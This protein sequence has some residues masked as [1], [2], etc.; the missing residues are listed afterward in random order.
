MAKKTALGKGLGALIEG[1]SKVEDGVTGFIKE[2]EIDKINP[3]PY[4]P[5]KE[6]DE[7][8]LE[9][10]AESIKAMGVIQ[11]ITINKND[12][13]SFTLISG[14]RRLRAA[15]LAHLET[16]PAYIRSTSDTQEMMEM[17]LVENIQRV[18]L[19]PISIAL[20]YQRLIDECQ[21]TQEKMSERIGKKR[22]TIANYLRLLKLPS[23]IQL[24]LKTNTISMGHA[25]AL[26]SID[27]SETQLMIYKEIIKHGFSV[28]KVEEIVREYNE[29]K[30]QKTNKPKTPKENIFEQ[31]QDKLSDYFSTKV[32]LSRNNKGKGKI[33]INF[34]NDDELEH[35]ISIFDKLNH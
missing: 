3:N 28:R 7:E 5:R 25:R 30:S 33:V 35:I 1:A 17:A 19:D 21:L 10:L 13:G 27:D 6:F 20:G 22:S 11:P 8:A 15:K 18:D 2:I 32:S 23:Q 24:G 34:A 26:I 29:D 14:E 9:E 16:I 12:D 31:L 4:Q